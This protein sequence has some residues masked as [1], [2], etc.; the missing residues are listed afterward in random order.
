MW[1]TW[2]RLIA[3]FRIVKYAIKRQIDELVADEIDESVLAR[4]RIDVLDVLELR[5][6]DELDEIDDGQQVEVRD[7]HRLDVMVETVEIDEFEV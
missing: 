6:L 3:D 4:K 1:M 7:V 2:A 5:H